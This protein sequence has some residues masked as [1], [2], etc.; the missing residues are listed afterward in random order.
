[1]VAA[2]PHLN[3]ELDTRDADAAQT[4]R[5][6][7]TGRGHA[8]FSADLAA[9]ILAAAAAPSSAAGGGG[10][11]GGGSSAGAAAA[12]AM[13]TPVAATGQLCN[14]CYCSEHGEGSVGVACDRDH[15]LCSECFTAYVES[16]SDTVGAANSHILLC[17]LQ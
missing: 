6:I 13:K 15:F 7:A 8:A 10:N 5:D 9:R 3:L 16:E 2:H 17:D 1:L 12:A 14:I 11:D 4:P